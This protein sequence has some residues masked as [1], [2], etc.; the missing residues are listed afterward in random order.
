MSPIGARRRDKT[1]KL[2]QRRFGVPEMSLL[3]S[4]N[5]VLSSCIYYPWHSLLFCSTIALQ[6]VD[7]YGNGCNLSNSHEQRIENRRRK[8]LSQSRHFV[9]RSCPHFR[10]ANLREGGMPFTP[11]L[12]MGRANPRRDRRKAPQKHGGYLCWPYALSRPA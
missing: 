3:L 2:A 5:I 8:S 1:S 6:G 10:A 11:S 4:F 9:R 12:N 7:Q